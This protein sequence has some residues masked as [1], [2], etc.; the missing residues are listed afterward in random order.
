M[1]DL[2]IQPQDTPEPETGAGNRQDQPQAISIQEPQTISIQEPQ[3][4]SIQEW[5]AISEPGVEE[6]PQP[7]ALEDAQLLA[8][9]E[10]C[11]YVAEEPLMPAQIAAA[12]QSGSRTHPRFTAN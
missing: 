9:L 7:E 5:K 3:T 12:L 4:I 1:E 8:V 2:E 6:A 10:A 11:V